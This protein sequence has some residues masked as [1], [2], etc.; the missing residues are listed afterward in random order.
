MP[1]HGD[2]ADSMR[3]EHKLAPASGETKFGIDVIRAASDFTN[4]GPAL[5]CAAG[6]GACDGIGIMVGVFVQSATI[7]LREGLEALLVIAA[8]AAYLRKAGAQERLP[9]LYGGAAV[10]ILASLIAAFLFEAFNNGEHNDVMEGVVILL[11]A[12]LM[13]YVSGWLLLRQ[14][15]KAWQGFLKTKADAALARRTAMA[16]AVLAFL[17]VFREGAETVLFIH[18]LA[19]TEGG[20]SVGLIGGLVAAAAGL[21][22]LFFVINVIAQRIPLRP[23]FIITSAFL[24]I[25]AIKFIGEAIQEFQEQVIVPSTIAPKAE[26]LLQ[27]GLNPTLEALGVQLAVIVLA[28]ITF[29][30]LDRRARHSA[31]KVRGEGPASW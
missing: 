20:W 5:I 8:L 13:L 26:W 7:L 27:I 16:V 24:F 22:V 17:A 4:A 9:A 2:T 11:A 21:V 1:G 31:D 23:L 25:M 15:P 18:A 14:D 28:L 6:G 12:A 3:L 30:V 29:V 19:K 10:A